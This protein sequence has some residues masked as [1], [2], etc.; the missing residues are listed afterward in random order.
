MVR[1]TVMFLAAG[2]EA[3]GEAEAAEAEVIAAFRPTSN[4]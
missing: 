4:R 1:L 2:G 3:V